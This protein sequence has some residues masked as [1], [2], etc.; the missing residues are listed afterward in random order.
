MSKFSDGF[1]EAPLLSDKIMNIFRKLRSHFN[2][3]EIHEGNIVISPRER[4][5]GYF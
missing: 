2:Q 1:T 4:E 3:P 5:W